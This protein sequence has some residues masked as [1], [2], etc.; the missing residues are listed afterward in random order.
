ME[1]NELDKLLGRRQI[2]FKNPINGFDDESV[3]EALEYAIP[4]HKQ[5]A[6]EIEFLFSYKKR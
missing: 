5:N 3:L 4:I 1:V 6:E 2:F